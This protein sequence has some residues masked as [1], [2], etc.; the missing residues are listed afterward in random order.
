MLKSFA[1]FA[2]SNILKVIYEM[3]NLETE[4]NKKKHKPRFSFPHADFSRGRGELHTTD[5]I[6]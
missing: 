6:D 1:I 4:K 2:F 3:N 5:E